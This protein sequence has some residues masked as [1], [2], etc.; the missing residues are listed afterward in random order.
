MEAKINFFEFF[1]NYEKHK[2]WFSP[3]FLDIISRIT[4]DNPFLVIN[5][6]ES[7]SFLVLENNS[8]IPFLKCPPRGISPKNFINL[9]SRRGRKKMKKILGL[10]SYLLENGAMALNSSY[11]KNAIVIAHFTRWKTDDWKIVY[12]MFDGDFWNVIIRGFNT[13]LPA[14][15]LKIS[16]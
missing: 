5:K 1:K 8:S 11:K 6:K 10:F 12:I 2:I 7:P 3:E 4:I 15:T 13:E 14:G 16:Y 9:S